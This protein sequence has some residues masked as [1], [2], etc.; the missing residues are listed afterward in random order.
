M[1]HTSDSNKGSQQQDPNRC[2]NYHLACKENTG[3]IE[4][5]KET[6]LYCQQALKVKYTQIKK[7]KKFKVTSGFCGL[8][9]IVLCFSQYCG[10]TEEELFVNL[11]LAFERE[12]LEML[13]LL[14]DLASPS[15]VLASV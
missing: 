8:L 4:S 1:P 13:H 3:F 14:K 2:D 11:T 6:S 12:S 15:H 7:N 9:L 5:T 10:K